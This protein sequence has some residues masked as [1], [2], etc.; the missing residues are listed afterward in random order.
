VTSAP[1]RPVVWLATPA[2]AELVAGLLVEFRDHLGRAWPSANAFLAGVE[3]LSEQPDTEYLLA[4][5]D[6]D[7]APAGVAQ[8]RYR[9]GLWHAAEDAYL[10]DLFV[11]APARGGGVG[12]ALVEG[13][14]A[15]AE[16]RACRRIQ[17]DVNDANPA[18]RALYERFGFSARPEGGEGEYLLMG[19][20]LGSE[21]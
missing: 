8:L 20:I 5:P 17:L 7:S 13:A 16:A 21:G 9:Y 14:V 18:G 12:S 1:S 11:R 3:R 4:T 15:R 6:P 19:R 10:E 2:E